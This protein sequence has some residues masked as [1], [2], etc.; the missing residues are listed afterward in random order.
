MRSTH[1]AFCCL[2]LS[3]SDN[4]ATSRKA[5]QSQRNKDEPLRRILWTGKKAAKQVDKQQ[6]EIKAEYPSDYSKH[7]LHPLS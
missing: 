3:G 6:R 1:V 2:P 4:H 5:Q 7:I